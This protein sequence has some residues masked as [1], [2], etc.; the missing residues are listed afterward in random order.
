MAEKICHATKKVTS[1]P[2][3][4]M[5]MAAHSTEI[6]SERKHAIHTADKDK[7]IEIAGKTHFLI[8]FSIFFD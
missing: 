4:P 3:K 1:A 6:G 5:N 7:A 8:T 2:K